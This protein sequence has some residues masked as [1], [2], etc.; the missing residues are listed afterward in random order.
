MRQHKLIMTAAVATALLSACSED[1]MV[2]EQHDGDAISFRAQTSN[3]TRTVDSYCNNNLPDQFTVYA[4]TSD[5]KKTLIDCVEATQ[6]ADGSETYKLPTANNYYWPNTEGVDF[7]AYRNDDGKFNQDFDSPKFENYVI[8]DDVA[9]QLDLI[10]AKEYGASRTST[11]GTVNLNFRHALSQVVFRANVTNKD[12]QVDITEVTIGN[13][14]NQGTFTFAQSNTTE[15]WTDETHND[16]NE[17]I[18]ESNPALVSAD[19]WSNRTCNDDKLHAYTIEIDNVTVNSATGVKDLS[20]SPTGH[21]AGGAWSKVM[22]LLPQSNEAWVPNSTNVVEKNGSY[23]RL[24]CEIFDI[25]KRKSSV[26][27]SNQGDEDITF[28]DSENDVL[29]HNGYVYVPLK[30]DWK[31]GIRY[32]YTINFGDGHAGYTYPEDP[33]N[34][35]DPTPPDDPIETLQEISITSQADDFIP[36]NEAV[37][38]DADYKFSGLVNLHSNDGTGNKK[39]AVMHSNYSNYLFTFDSKYNLARDGYTFQGWVKNANPTSTNTDKIY[40]EGSFE[41]LTLNDNEDSNV[42]DY[43]AFWGESG[44]TVKYTDGAGGGVFGGESHGGLTEGDPTP[45]YNSGTERAGYKF[46]GWKPAFNEIVWD[47]MATDKV[48]TYE[49]QWEKID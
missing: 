21:N 16:E 26:D 39:V 17:V 38:D 2:S 11:G 14:Q 43:Y 29:L 27:G 45:K 46:I 36:I 28:T 9:E 19:G 8:E 4:R 48:I 13:L 35:D 3:L 22:T 34:P 40:K 49:A 25:S 5:T 47:D 30:V 31:S 24:K 6:D 15:T 10:Y 37:N 7:L 18:E 32:V 12:L 20:C 33:K 44:Y 23:I 41:T 42:F 1:V